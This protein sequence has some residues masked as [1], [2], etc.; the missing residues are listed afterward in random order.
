MSNTLEPE[1]LRIEANAL[2]NRYN[3]LSTKVSQLENAAEAD[4][5]AKLDRLDTM[6]SALERDVLELDSPEVTNL[7]TANRLQ[8]TIQSE[9]NDLMLEVDTLSQGNPTTVSAALDATMRAVD[10]VETKLKDD[11]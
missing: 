3:E 11:H 6:V 5:Q 9:L 4:F 2:R 8:S 10:K 7:E 1:E